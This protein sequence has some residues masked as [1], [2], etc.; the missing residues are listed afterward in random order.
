MNVHVQRNV[1]D[2][3]PHASFGSGP[4]FPSPLE[5]V[6]DLTG[7]EQVSHLLLLSQW[8][9]SIST[10]LTCPCPWELSQLCQS[11]V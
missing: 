1:T 7:N 6:I 9:L 3:Q 4:L 2:A 11:E 10:F 8:H 5:D